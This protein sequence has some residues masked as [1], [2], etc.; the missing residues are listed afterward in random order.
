[1]KTAMI[2]LAVG[3]LLVL[4]GCA[5]DTPVDATPPAPPG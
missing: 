2:T 1:M 5:I 4:D 3:A